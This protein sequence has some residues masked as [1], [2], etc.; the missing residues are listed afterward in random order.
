MARVSS[1]RTE[2]VS[3][4]TNAKKNF[5]INLVTATSLAITELSV[6]IT[7]VDTNVPVKMDSKSTLAS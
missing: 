1:T 4:M 5:R 7:L 6:Q 3:T 2:H